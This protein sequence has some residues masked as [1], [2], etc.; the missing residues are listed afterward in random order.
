MSKRKEL[1]EAI[2]ANAREG[3]AAKRSVIEALHWAIHKAKEEDVPKQKTKGLAQMIYWEGD[4]FYQ[5]LVF[6]GGGRV[7]IFARDGEDQLEGVFNIH[8][9]EK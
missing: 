8:D 4:T 6:L 1:I 7:E 5:E 2:L 9:L 3:R